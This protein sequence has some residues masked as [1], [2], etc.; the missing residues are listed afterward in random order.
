M[1]PKPLRMTYNADLIFT[2]PDMTMDIELERARAEIRKHFSG[3]RAIVVRGAESVTALN[4]Q[5]KRPYRPSMVAHGGR[6]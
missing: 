4:R 1:L 6:A 2:F 5:T 3:H